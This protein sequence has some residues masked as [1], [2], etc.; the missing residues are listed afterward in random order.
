MKKRNGYTMIEVMI[1]LVIMIA[2]S[3]GI[4]LSSDLSSVG[5]DSKNKMIVNTVAS[6]VSQF[7][8]E[9]GDY[10]VQLNDLTTKK[11]IYGPYLLAE[12]LKDT[13]GQN[14]NYSFSVDQKFFMVWSNGKNKVSNS[15]SG[16]GLIAGD[17]VGI[18]IRQ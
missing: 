7:K 10:P 11:D 12:N 16:I 8:F 18:V 14:I 1:V 13:Y 4:F 6:A 17:D 2:L 15:N 3:A 9:T 5:R